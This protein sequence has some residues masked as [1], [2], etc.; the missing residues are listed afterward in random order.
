MTGVNDAVSSDRPYRLEV[1]LA[2]GSILF[3]AVFTRLGQLDLIDFKADEAQIASLA[4]DV[5]LGKWPAASIQTSLGPFNPPLF[6]YLLA[7]PML[8]SSSPVALTGL[9]G[10]SNVLAVL[11]TYL[12]GSRYFN[13]TVGLTAALFFAV[14]PYAVIFARKL[15]G[16]FVEPLV[17]VGLLACLLRAVGTVGRETKQAAASYRLEDAGRGRRPGRLSNTDWL[18]WAGA[19]VCLA[20][21]V[22][23]H[24]A[25]ALLA[26]VI[27]PLAVL[28]RRRGWLVGIAAGIL[29][30]VALFIPY[31]VFEINRQPEFF[32]TLAGS[33]GGPAHWDLNSLYLGWVLVSAGDY[34]DVTGAAAGIYRAAVP[35]Y[36]WLML[37]VGVST[38]AGLGLCVRRWRDPR[39]VTLGLF[40]LLPLLLTIRHTIGLQIHYFA[41]LLPAFFLLG[42]IAVNDAISR[43]PKAKRP[44]FGLLILLGATQLLGF[45]FFTDFLLNH[46]LSGAFGVPLRYEQQ[47]LQEAVRLAQGDRIVVAATGRDQ[48][49]AVRY[50]LYGQPQLEVEANRGLVLPDAPRAVYVTMGDGTASHMALLKAGP[51]RR[52]I[53]LPGTDNFSIFVTSPVTFDRVQAGLSMQPVNLAFN[54]GTTLVSR[55]APTALP[56]QLISAWQVQ[57]PVAASTTIFNQ[58]LDSSGKQWFDLDSVPVQPSEWQSGDRIIEFVQASVPAEAPRQGYSW[59][60][61]MYV[62]NGNRVPLADNSLEAHIAIMAGGKPAAPAVPPHPVGATFGATLRLDG[63]D[64]APGKVT[65]FWT[66]IQRPSL[67]Y[68]VFVHAV[69]SS[70]VVVAQHDSQPLDGRFPTS[71]WQNGESVQDSVPITAPAGA[72]LEVGLYDLKSGQRLT[73]SDGTDHVNIPVP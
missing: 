59:S 50:L 7:I 70:G 40:A 5:L 3:I 26:L 16:N 18:P 33:I 37:V 15:L 66:S 23:L 64:L 47:V 46:D 12:I 57:R 8:L 27:L 68:T 60:I 61:G 2:L 35:P 13:K 48:T 42:G 62:Q 9:V 25:P 34:S 22:Q 29:V 38:I 31:L 67:D 69:S 11:G 20:L 39:Y 54:N 19:I 14:D 71:L 1:P 36:G 30:G 55:A 49:E 28:Y 52:I 73:L 65:L 56:G 53:Q 43:W 51:P 21:L 41:F 63:Y 72:H 44:V 24:P 6:V 45:R 4:R 17:A 32:R 10:L 58:I